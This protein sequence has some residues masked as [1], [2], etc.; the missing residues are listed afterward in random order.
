LESAGGFG[1]E[2][3]GD[4]IGV[5]G[6]DEV[7]DLD[8]VAVIFVPCGDDGAGDGFAGVGDFDFEG[9]DGKR[10]GRKRR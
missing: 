9:H 7:A 2:F 1:L 8:G 4:L 6:D 3:S 5:D 10:K